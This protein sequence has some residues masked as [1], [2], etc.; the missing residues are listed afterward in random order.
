MGTTLAGVGVGLIVFGVILWAGSY[1]VSGIADSFDGR[2]SSGTRNW[3]G[4]V[5]S[6]GVTVLGYV[7]AAVARR[8]PLTTAGVAASAL[9]VPTALVFMTLDFTSGSPINVD[10]V[11]VVSIIV[12]LL[13][14]TPRSQARAGTAST[15]GS[16]R[17]RSGST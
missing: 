14:A 10:A 17:S 1:A 9:G 16:A 7:L 12:W 15:W 5:L 11:F 3:L 2:G 8:G 4:I 6:L 13:R